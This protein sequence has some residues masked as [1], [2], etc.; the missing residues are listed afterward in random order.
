M[1]I[2]TSVKAVVST[3]R[4]DKKRHKTHQRAMKSNLERSLKRTG[5][6]RK[7]DIDKD[8]DEK[9]LKRREQR[10]MR[11][12]NNKVVLIIKD[13]PIIFINELQVCYKC[14]KHGHRLEECPVQDNES[15]ICFKCGSTEHTVKTCKK[16]VPSG[17]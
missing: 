17:Q 11:R 2:T 12:A 3:G 5:K 6:R 16:Y 8:V 4:V 15:G 7:Q 10:R 9:R 1:S 13:T 14:R